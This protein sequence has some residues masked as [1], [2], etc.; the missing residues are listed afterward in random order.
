MALV[1][2]MVALNARL[3]GIPI[4]LGVPQYQTLMIRHVVLDGA[5]LKD[6][7]DTLLEPKT[8]I[9]TVPQKLVGLPTGGV[10]AFQASG[11]ITISL[12]DFQVT[13]IPRSY[14]LEFLRDNV[15]V[16]VIDPPIGADGAIAYDSKG[17]PA[18]GIFC[19]LLHIEDKDLLTWSL[20]LRQVRDHYVDGVSEVLY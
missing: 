6:V 12:E 1:D 19:K 10:G 18:S 17:N 15:D 20:I 16:Y 4:R 7:T 13:G 3:T 5:L 9:T 14:S 8:H 11:G 2:R